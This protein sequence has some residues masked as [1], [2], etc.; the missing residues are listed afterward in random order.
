LPWPVAPRP[1]FFP[2]DSLMPGAKRAQEHKWAAVGNRDMS[3][4]IVR[5]EVAHLE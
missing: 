5:H 3:S 2:A 1:L 4:P